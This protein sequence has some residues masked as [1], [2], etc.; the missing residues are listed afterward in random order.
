M[1]RECYSGL[2]L[3][4]PHWLIYS[5]ALTQVPKPPSPSK[6]KA[7]IAME[8]NVAAFGLLGSSHM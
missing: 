8:A 6:I 5:S 2:T 7:V 3:T 4:N 1:D